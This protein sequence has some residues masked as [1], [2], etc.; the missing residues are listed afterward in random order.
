MADQ[1]ADF[2]LR[3]AQADRLGVTLGR[4]FAEY[5][6]WHAKAC[7]VKGFAADAK[8]AGV[9][10]VVEDRIQQSVELALDRG[11]IKLP[12]SKV[13]FFAEYSDN[14][15]KEQLAVAEVGGK[16]AAIVMLH[17]AC[18]RYFWR[19]VRFGLVLNR[20][21]AIEWT[22]NRKV[23]IGELAD[24]DKEAVIDAEIEKWWNGLERDS[25]IKKW[26]K[27]IGL[28]GF[29]EGLIEKGWRFDEEMLSVFD[30]V[31]NNAVHHDGCN[32]KTFDMDT[33]TTQLW[34]AQ[35]VWVMHLAQHM[36]LTI[37]GEVMFSLSTE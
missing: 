8:L 2:P 4:C 6:A 10:S 13:D 12:A 11:I 23:S 1:I 27:L 21:K 34:R 31:R 29:P 16:T 5:N 36:A 3:S 15:V 33:F 26:K 32:I 37:P 17:N 18:E 25:I 30:E 20:S 7:L 14:L 24:Q 9:G 35:L 28:A 19:L 22:A